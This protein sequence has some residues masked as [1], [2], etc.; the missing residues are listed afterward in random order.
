MDGIEYVAGA[1][2]F[3][4]REEGRILKSGSTYAYEYYLRDHLGNSRVG[5]TQGTNVTT[6]NFT[7][8]YY[9]AIET[10]S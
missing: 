9:K 5:F 7:A 6:P 4:H 2:E 1:I 8:D 3:I 10:R